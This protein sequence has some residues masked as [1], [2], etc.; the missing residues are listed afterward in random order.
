MS[1]PIRIGLLGLG[2]VAQAVHLPLLARRSDL[3]RIAAVCELAPDVLETIGDRYGIERSRRFADYTAMLDAGGLDAVMILS[4]GS[5]APAVLAAFER[6][7]AVFCEKPLAFTTAEVDEV[8][9][10]QPDLGHPALLLA[11]MKQ[12]DPA[13]TAA[14]QALAE[15]DDVRLVEAMVLHPTGASQLDFARV[16]GSTQPLPQRAVDANAAE[17]ATLW[18]AAVGDADDALWR[19][20]RGSL[21]SSLAHDLS[22]LRSLGTVPETVEYADIWR[23]RS[24]FAVREVGRDRMSHG[25]HPAS[26]A[27]QG[28]LASGGRYTLGWHYLP[29]FP[30][31]RETVRV[32]HGRGTVELV[33][34]SPYLL[35]APTELTVTTPDG[36]AERKMVRRSISE[37]FENQLVAFHAMLRDGRPPKSALSEGRDD[38]RICQ[39]I[40]AA[41]AARTGARV[42]GEVGALLPL[43]PTR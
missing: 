35:Q 22:V 40:V 19:T 2:A 7:L 15:V 36:D 8:L 13:V 29:D 9:A 21:V 32:V 17:D 39:Q 30:A 41:Y 10:A 37:A 20:Y 14:A 25:A 12:Y 31:Y 24:R 3:Y 6:R 5:H 1:A 38:I 43:Q 34:P 28:G 18:A 42:G 16:V 11:Y 26:I 33:F 23:Q 27:V 4:R